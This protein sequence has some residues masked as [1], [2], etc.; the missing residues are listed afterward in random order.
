MLHKEIIASLDDEIYTRLSN[1]GGNRGINF[2]SSADIVSYNVQTYDVIDKDMIDAQKAIVSKRFDKSIEL[3]TNFSNM[4][5]ANLLIPVERRF[6]DNELFALA[7]DNCSGPDTRLSPCAV[8]FRQLPGFTE[9]TAGFND[10]RNFVIRDN[11]SQIYDPST[12]SLAFKDDRDFKVR[13]AA[14]AHKLALAATLD[15]SDGH[16]DLG[17]AATKMLSI[18]EADMKEFNRLKAKAAKAAARYSGGPTTPAASTG[19]IFGKICF[20]CGWGSHNSRRC[21]IMFRAP[22]GSFTPNQM[23]LVKFSP[24]TDPHMIDGKAICQ[25]VAPGYKP[26]D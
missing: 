24:S 22:A 6:N 3:S 14:P 13:H 17:L 1:S 4:E 20:N 21:S 11:S 23:A 7:F 8:K 25:V 19:L 10:F 5:R 16:V 2:H 15:I 26:R 12:A 9:L 18:S